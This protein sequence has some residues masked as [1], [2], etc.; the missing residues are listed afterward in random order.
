MASEINSSNVSSRSL[1]AN[2][3][4]RRLERPLQNIQESLVIPATV[5]R[6]SSELNRK[7]CHV[8]VTLSHVDELFNGVSSSYGMVKNLHLLNKSRVREVLKSQSFIARFCPH[9]GFS[10][11]ETNN[12]SNS[13]MIIG[14]S[15]RFLIK[16]KR[17][18]HPLHLPSIWPR[19]QNVHRSYQC[20][21]LR[22]W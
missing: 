11:Q 15:H 13:G 17:T 8:E 16:Y 6:H 7:I 19:I 10:L 3:S 22:R 1:L 12:I 2:T 20:R 18:L 14:I 9:Q 21:E 5:S 4:L